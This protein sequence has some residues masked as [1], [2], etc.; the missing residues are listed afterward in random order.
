[1]CVFVFLC[2]VVTAVVLVSPYIIVDSVTPCLENGIWRDR[3]TRMNV[4]IHRRTVGYGAGASTE[5]GLLFQ[6]LALASQGTPTVWCRKLLMA[7]M[8]GLTLGAYMF[9]FVFHALA[10]CC[11][12]VCWQ[13]VC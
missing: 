4:L 9:L 2:P 5:Y 1:M 13:S 3:K 10:T 6:V 12:I 8:R 11:F 7:T